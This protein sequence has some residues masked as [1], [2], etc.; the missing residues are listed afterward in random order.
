MFKKIRQ[1]VSTLS[2]A[3]IFIVLT[4]IG[5]TIFVVKYFGL[6]KEWKVIR[7]EVIKQGWTENS[8]PYGYRAPFWL[9]GK[10][11]VGQV[12]RDVNSGK[13]I[14]TLINMENYLRSGEEADIYLTLKVEVY[15]NTRNGQ[16]FYKDVPLDLGSN[17]TLNLN[18]ILIP[19]QITDTDVPPNGYP[20]KYFL[21]TTLAR[22]VNNWI[23][24]QVTPGITMKNRANNETV[25]EILSVKT[26]DPIYQE[27][28]TDNSRLAVITANSD[29]DVTMTM[30]IKALQIDGRW[31]FGGHQ[32]LNIGNVIYIHP[33]TTLIPDSTIQ[34]FEELPN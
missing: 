30:K 9:S 5:L 31:Y 32:N 13:I 26:E 11:K 14:A 23:Y 3:E 15:H 25:V 19:G 8:N 28:I 22:N 10:I 4:I 20:T 7:V 16:Y 17:I 27:I 6:K 21:V 24:S 33:N 2:A 29:K 12:E 18:N 1:R 34:K